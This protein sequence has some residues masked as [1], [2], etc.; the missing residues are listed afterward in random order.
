MSDQGSSPISSPITNPEQDKQ[1]IKAAMSLETIM[2][3]ITTTDEAAAIKTDSASQDPSLLGAMIYATELQRGQ[4][5]ATASTSTA[6]AS[7]TPAA[8]AAIPSD[9]MDIDHD[10]AHSH[11]HKQQASAIS[12]DSD[13]DSVAHI[14]IEEREFICLNDEYSDC[15]TGQVTKSLSRKVISN[16]FGR[17]KACTRMIQDWPLFCRKHYQRAT[18]KP[19]L[20]QRRKVNLILRQFDIIEKQ[21]PGTTYEVQF[22]KAEE[23]RLNEYS[24]KVTAGM[25]ETDAAALVAPNANIKSFQAPISVLRELEGYLGMDKSLDTVKEAVE[26]ILELLD[27]NESTEVPSIEFLP[28]IPKTKAPAAARVST[29]GAIKKPTKA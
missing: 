12:D 10:R 6:S 26:L 15:V 20:W 14:P 27:T 1:D 21:Y 4:A 23:A 9:A 18:Y 19:E 24:R 16:H 25:P 11:D 13:L 17:N 28:G 22:K 2:S 5:A 8:A 7:H 29:K 3:S